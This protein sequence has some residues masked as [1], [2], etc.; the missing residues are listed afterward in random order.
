MQ[1]VA[2][3]A[4][5]LHLS[6]A[7]RDHLFRLAGLQPPERG[8]AGEHVSPGMQ[9]IFDRLSTP[10]PRSSELGATLRQTRLGAAVTGDLTGF[11]G[12]SR[13]IIHRWFMD[14][15]SRERYDPDEHAFLTRLWA[16]G[17]REIATVRG[18]D[19]DAAELADLL[20][21][22]SDEFRA[23][24]ERNEVGLRPRSAKR[25]NHPEV[26]LLALTCQTLIDPDHGHTLLVYTAEPGSESAEKLRL[27]SVIAAPTAPLS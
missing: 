21:R 16:S 1:M 8:A 5:G 23:A 20:L 11:V 24:W 13:S 17:L 7:E 14:P 3:I 12:P 9:R 18:R 2:S 19:S 25:F 6:R 27:L 10:Q 26:G 4:Q 22:D 15:R